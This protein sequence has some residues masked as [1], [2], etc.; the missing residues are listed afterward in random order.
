MEWGVGS[1]DRGRPGTEEVVGQTGLPFAWEL[2]GS[3]NSGPALDP[4]AWVQGPGFHGAPGLR[5]AAG[6]SPS[7]FRQEAMAACSH[8]LGMTRLGPPAGKDQEPQDPSAYTLRMSLSWVW[9][10][11]TSALGF[12]FFYLIYTHTSA[13]TLGKGKKSSSRSF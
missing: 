3:L 1:P 13:S 9:F 6:D 2:Q 11:N 7:L 5:E 8:V 12:H 10:Q 4:V